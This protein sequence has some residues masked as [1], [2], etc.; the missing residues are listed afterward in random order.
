MRYKKALGE[1]SIPLSMEVMYEDTLDEVPTELDFAA[2]VAAYG[3]I[4]RDSKYKGTATYEMAFDLV[5]TGLGYD[6]YGYRLQLQTM[7]AAAQ[8][9]GL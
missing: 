9:M 3:M 2:G 4:L 7:I 6:P 1:E 5:G 8:K